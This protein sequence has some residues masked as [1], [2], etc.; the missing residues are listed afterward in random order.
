VAATRR[1]FFDL[2]SNKEVDLLTAQFDRLLANLDRDD[3]SRRG[4]DSD[5]RA[6]PKPRR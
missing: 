2:L 4:R 3:C 5:G 1:Y 6:G